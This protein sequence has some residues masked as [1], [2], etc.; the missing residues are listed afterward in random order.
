MTGTAEDLGLHV[1]PHGVVDRVVSSAVALIEGVEHASLILV[2]KGRVTSVAATSATGRE[3][4]ALQV[5]LGQG[6]SLDAVLVEPV[7]VVGD[8]TE[9][10]RWPD[11][12]RRAPTELRVRSVLCFRLFVHGDVLGGLTLLAT[13]PN[14]FGHRA[15][16]AG[17]VF[18]ADA[19]LTLAGAHEVAHLTAALVN[20]DVIGQAKGILM[21]R[22]R[23]SDQQAFALLYQASQDRNL[24]LHVLAEQLTRSGS[25]ED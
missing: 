11:L 13:G 5:Q 19:A 23:I 18:V 6:P 3:F 16:A 12:A 17:A 10:Q 14:A 1:S 24:K 20:R 2:R 4:H 21:E 7:V 25:W 8:L 9:E 15:Q 22:H